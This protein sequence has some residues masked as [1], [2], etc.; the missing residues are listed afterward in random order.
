MYKILKF[1]GIS[2]K[3]FIYVYNDI[4]YE[5]NYINGVFVSSK[6]LYYCFGMHYSYEDVDE[7]SLAL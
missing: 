4:V 5:Y 2:G 6:N 3:F 7:E 1:G